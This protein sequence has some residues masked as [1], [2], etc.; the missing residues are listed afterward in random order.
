MRNIR[1][2]PD[3]FPTYRGALSQAMN[4]RTDVALILWNR[5]VIQLMSLV[6]LQR[7]LE[8]C[9]VEPSDGAERIERF[10]RS[11]NPSVVVFDLHPPYDRSAAVALRMMDRFPGTSFVLTCADS[12]LAMK[13][14]P[15]LSRCLL[16]Q[17]PYELDEIADAVRSMVRPFPIAM[18]ALTTEV[19]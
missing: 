5:D 3:S 16:F 9:G 15:W 8:S 1:N 19:S 12:V 2:L 18:G 10:L 17:K 13:K 4:T 7:N 6:L 14:A 11:C